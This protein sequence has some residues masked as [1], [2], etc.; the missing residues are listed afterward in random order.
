MSLVS[1][2]GFA[3]IQGVQNVYLFFTGEVMMFGAMMFG[4]YRIK[5]IYVSNADAVEKKSDQIRETY[6][7]K[8]N[9]LGEMMKELRETGKIVQQANVEKYENANKSILK[10]FKSEKRASTTGDES[11][12][13]TIMIVLFSIGFIFLLSS[14]FPYNTTHNR[15]INKR[16]YIYAK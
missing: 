8:A 16:H 10:I 14:F 4:L 5:V 2:F 9:A 15:H 7:Q 1:G 13:I 6:E 12:F 3:G 11:S